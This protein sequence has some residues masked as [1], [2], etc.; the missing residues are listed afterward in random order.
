MD[1]YELTYTAEAC[2]ALHALIAELLDYGAE[3][4]MYKN[5][6]V[7][8]LV[9]DGVSTE[10]V[11]DADAVESV[12]AS[13]AV[14]GESGAKFCGATVRFDNTTYIRFDFTLGTASLSDVQVTIGDKV[15]T[16]EDL[17]T[18][19][20]GKYSVYTDAI[21]ATNF[22]K[23]YTAT[24]LVDGETAHTVTY[25]VNSYVKVMHS[26]ES[27]GALAIATYHYGEAARAFAAALSSGV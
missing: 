5:Y 16:E 18:L 9:N 2:D 4:Q 24:L 17:L 1:K 6:K 8:E 14:S 26:S 10:N 27:M 20:E 11:F 19:E 3:A 13:S 15:Y 25:S 23:A 22:A 7:D 12:K 21:S